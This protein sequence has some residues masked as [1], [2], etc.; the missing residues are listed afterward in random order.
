MVVLGII[1]LLVAAAL[2]LLL[3]TAG[4]SQD[5]VLDLVGGQQLTTSPILVFLAGALTVALAVIGFWLISRGTR[6]AVARRR[7]IRNL[8]QAASAPPERAAARARAEQDADDSAPASDR[9]LVRDVDELRAREGLAPAAGGGHSPEATADPE[10]GRH[11]LRL[12]DLG[13]PEHRR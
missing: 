5:I 6:R 12:D 3:V 7:E 9:L 11:E 8:R 4:T 13:T 1:V 10:G 2:V